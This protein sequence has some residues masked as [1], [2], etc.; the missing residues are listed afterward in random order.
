MSFLQGIGGVILWDGARSSDLRNAFKF[1][2]MKYETKGYKE[3][4]EYDVARI[5]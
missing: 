4:W 1:N 2:N 5:A 3:E